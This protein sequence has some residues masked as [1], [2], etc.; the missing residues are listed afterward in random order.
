M[1]EEIRTSA[2]GIP[3]AIKDKDARKAE[4][5]TQFIGEGAAGTSTADY[6]QWAGDKANTGKYEASDTVFVSVNGKRAGRTPL[7]V[8]GKLNGAFQ[9]LAKAVAAKAT[10]LAD[11]AEH[12]GR[13]FNVGEQELATWLTTNGY[14]ETP[15][16][17]IEPSVWTPAKAESPTV[18]AEAPAAKVGP[19]PAKMAQYEAARNK[20]KGAAVAAAPMV[21]AE[22]PAKA[23]TVKA[24]APAKAPMAKAEAP[25]K[26]QALINQ[27]RTLEEVATGH[28]DG[29][30]PNTDDWLTSKAVEEFYTLH[31]ATLAP[32]LGA[33]QE[34]L[35]TA[36]DATRV[37]LMEDAPVA[38]F[39]HYGLNGEL[40][41][42]QAVNKDQGELF[43]KRH[44]PTPGQTPDQ[45][46][47][48]IKH[49]LLDRANIHVLH[50]T[51]D[52]PFPVAPDTAGLYL[53]DGSA[54][55]FTEN[56]APGEEWAK[57]FHEVG[58]HYGL[59]RMVGRDAY[60]AILK[61]LKRM[62]AGDGFA[63]VKEAHR[64]AV[65]AGATGAGVYHETLGY[66]A[67]LSPRH[68]LVRRLITAVRQFLRSIGLVKA[69][70]DADLVGLIQA[71]ALKEGLEGRV[72]LSK[73]QLRSTKEG[74]VIR[75][76]KNALDDL[77]I[78]LEESNQGVGEIDL[79]DRI[80]RIAAG[81]EGER[82][83]PRIAARFFTILG[84][85]LPAIKNG[86]WKTV[87]LLPGYKALE[88]PIS[89]DKLD[90]ISQALEDAFNGVTHPDSVFQEQITA[91]AADI[92]KRGTDVLVPESAYEGRELVDLE[93]LLVRFPQHAELVK[94]FSA[95]GFTLTGS[96]SL[97]AQGS[98]L[99]PDENPF[100]DLDFT[101]PLWLTGEPEHVYRQAVQDV[102]GYTQ[103]QIARFHTIEAKKQV[104]DKAGVDPNTPGFTTFS[105]WVPL[106]PA[107]V[108]TVAGVGKKTQPVVI[109]K[110]TGK[111]Q[112]SAATISIDIFP[113]KNTAELQ[114]AGVRISRWDE[115]IAAKFSF[116]RDGE[117]LRDKDV[118]D[119]ALFKGLVP[120]D[121]LGQKL[122]RRFETHDEYQKVPIFKKYGLEGF[123]NH[124]KLRGK[125]NEAVKLLDRKGFPKTLMEGLSRI[126]VATKSSEPGM[127][128]EN[129]LVMALSQTTL[130]TGSIPDIAA[131][132]AHELTHDLDFQLQR[133]QAET[134]SSP[135]FAIE[136]D[137]KGKVTLGPIIKELYSLY[138]TNKEGLLKTFRY[139]FIDLQNA[140][141]K[142]NQ[143][144]LAGIKSE[145]FAQAGM[146]YWMNP[147]ALQK[148][149]PKTYALLETVYAKESEP[150]RRNHVR[151]ERT[152]LYQRVRGALWPPSS[153]DQGPETGG[154]ANG[155]PR[156]RRPGPGMGRVAPQ[157]A[158]GLLRGRGLVSEPQ[159]S[160]GS[161]TIEPTLDDRGGKRLVV[162]YGIFGNGQLLESFDSA[163]EAAAA[164]KKNRAE[165][166][167]YLGE[168]G[169]KPVRA[170]F[171]N[172]R[173][174]GVL[175]NLDKYLDT[176]KKERE[177]P[178]FAPIGHPSVNP[179]P[180]EPDAHVVDYHAA[181]MR[182]VG[183]LHA[184]SPEGDPAKPKLASHLAPTPLARLESPALAAMA[185]SLR[186][187]KDPVDAAEHALSLMAAPE[188]EGIAQL[189]N[190][191]RR[192][193]AQ[194]LSPERTLGAIEYLYATTLQQSDQLRALTAFVSQDDLPLHEHLLR[195]LDAFDALRRADSSVVADIERNMLPTAE[196]DTAFGQKERDYLAT[197]KAQQ[198]VGNSA[199]EIQV[200]S[201]YERDM[202]VHDTLYPTAA[203][204]KVISPLVTRTDSADSQASKDEKS[205]RA[206]KRL[207]ALEQQLL[208]LQD[209]AAANPSQTAEVA[210][211]DME[212]WLNDGALTEAGEQLRTAMKKGKPDGQESKLLADLQLQ[213][214]WHDATAAP[215]GVLV[216]KYDAQRLGGDK[217]SK[218]SGRYLL[219]ERI[220]T[221]DPDL[222]Q[223]VEDP[224]T[225]DLVT[226]K[227]WVR[228]LISEVTAYW[229]GRPEA[230]NE[231]FWKDNVLEFHAVDK[232]FAPYPGEL[233]GGPVDMAGVLEGKKTRKITLTAK[234]VVKIGKM[235]YKAI[236][237]PLGQTPLMNYEMGLQT[238]LYDSG[239][240]YVMT[241][242]SEQV[243]DRKLLTGPYIAPGVV[244][245]DDKKGLWLGDARQAQARGQADLGVAADDEL[246]A[247]KEWVERKGENSTAFKNWMKEKGLGNLRFQESPKAQKV[248]A[249]LLKKW[250]SQQTNESPAFEEWLDNK[251][252]VAF[253]DRP[254]LQGKEGET[255]DGRGLNTEEEQAGYSARMG[256]IGETSTKVTGEKA[257]PHKAGVSRHEGTEA[258]G[259]VSKIVKAL[260]LNSIHVSLYNR[261]DVSD[262]LDAVEPYTQTYNRLRQGLLGATP[263]KAAVAFIDGRILLYYDKN[264]TGKEL[265][266]ALGHEMGHV[267]LRTVLENERR[268]ST[269][270]WRRLLSQYQASES[271]E[272]FMEWFADQAAQWSLEDRSPKNLIEAFYRRVVDYFNK[273]LGAIGAKATPNAVHAYLDG[274]ALKERAME[275]QALAEAL[276]GTTRYDLLTLQQT[277]HGADTMQ[278]LVLDSPELDFLSP[279][280][281]VKKTAA[282]VKE[283]VKAHQTVNGVV[284]SVTKGR[285][286]VVEWGH[287]V[288]DTTGGW[289]RGLNNPA[290]TMLA[291]M[292]DNGA[293]IGV[294]GLLNTPGDVR[295]TLEAINQDIRKRN[296]ARDPGALPEPFV[297]VN[298]LT[299]RAAQIFKNRKADGLLGVKVFTSLSRNGRR[300][301]EVV[302]QLRESFAAA[303]NRED[304]GH[305]GASEGGY[306]K[307]WHKGTTEAEYQAIG[308][309][310]LRNDPKSQRAKEIAAWLKGFFDE[311]VAPGFTGA[312]SPTREVH[313]GF[314]EDWGMARFYSPEKIAANRQAFLDLLMT[315][316]DSVGWV[317][318]QE[319][320]ARNLTARIETGV[321]LLPQEQPTTLLSPGAASRKRRNI[322]LAIDKLLPFLETDISKT[323]PKYVHSMV[324]RVE[325]D[326]RFS[327]EK[328][329]GK[330][331]VWHRN[332]FFDAL[333]GAAEFNNDL[334]PQRQA[335]IREQINGI[336]EAA[337]GRYGALGA[338][339]RVRTGMSF[340]QTATN[341]LVLPLAAL[342]QGTDFASPFIRTGGDLKNSL[343]GMREAFTAMRNTG[344]DVYKMA[345]M[346]GVIFRDTRNAFAASYLDAPYMTEGA[347]KWNDSLF[348]WNGMQWLTT[349]NRIAAWQTSG[350][351]LKDMAVNGHPDATRLLAQL[352]L[353]TKDLEEWR[354]QEFPDY[355]NGGA[356]DSVAYKVATARTR[357]VQE[358][359]FAPNATQR[360]LLANHP[361]AMLFWSL[362]SFTY[363]YFTQMIKPILREVKNNPRWA[364]KAAAALPL[365]VLLPLAMAGMAFRDELKYGLGRDARSPSDKDD[366]LETTGKV[367]SRTGIM[368]PLQLL[369]DADTASSYGRSFFFALAS[370]TLSKAEE[371]FRAGSLTPLMPGLSMLPA[372][373]QALMRWMAED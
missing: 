76:L 271:P 8:D 315:D 207:P 294:D 278:R 241:Q 113:Y 231:D 236:G 224:K 347:Q 67:E 78:T 11:N 121:T 118:I 2:R 209:Q 239:T 371:A 83:I 357:F 373:R 242:A 43:S 340:I 53:P 143:E 197:V 122:E 258:H 235:M 238:L 47:A 66:L 360:P 285:R 163:E 232:L 162:G 325:W 274:L 106:D 369:M 277:Y 32:L 233:S 350:H 91:F 266:W 358:S 120:R 283:W 329:N 193:F 115:I 227:E 55:F 30:L 151:Y 46:R 169:A 70:T 310:L 130:E 131:V 86:L 302:P 208:A 270:L 336:G 135:L 216:L 359:N 109:D 211:G 89:T 15:G 341:F 167:G 330:K 61:D 206:R 44:A 100:H 286:T 45:F 141:A 333:R 153:P 187:I 332:V 348:K 186:A 180:R 108:L 365:L 356:K 297:D 124:P 311:Y 372:E 158:G 217:G 82:L 191:Y 243:A 361:Y 237:S 289:L 262:L 192:I 366:W 90:I 218:H 102:L 171:A 148:A 323:L 79:L 189:L 305:W 146:L 132:I 228:R 261:D 368:G 13:G 155:R 165:Y 149:A 309:E 99:R 3:Q 157:N 264:L 136:K 19:S 9:N 176:D 175:E 69:Y 68:G 229:D 279:T 343:K 301:T 174:K 159:F 133:G 317:G 308:E 50:R 63:S 42:K 319:A 246:R 18:Q 210:L 98:V 142:G 34:Q 72:G 10:I 288:L 345:E 273:L 170:E 116:I 212:A 71:A 327:D 26:V 201:L 349:F 199:G 250:Q 96:A 354:D 304:K 21:K 181:L 73:G 195:A 303:V 370:P 94:K 182:H 161:L 226:P 214:A 205:W 251:E 362:K 213:R 29:V 93:K 17:G 346:M 22:A 316:D 16:K 81:A 364:S 253:L 168:A 254:D 4:L 183:Q 272:S 64:R 240:H 260:N 247:F 291:D 265:A 234:Q 137:A 125:V 259:V 293:R 196:A 363:S 101:S 263:K 202:L 334:P 257:L 150:A 112:P 87:E 40:Y 245:T 339:P 184:A 321:E 129:K 267:V 312:Y 222:L 60:A 140:I 127:L 41:K 219:V 282:A 220:T 172:P 49:K 177:K 290:S 244:V 281:V 5:M 144:K 215:Y 185:E 296:L 200:Q 204:G 134:H 326:R 104:W 20:A 344:G 1:A 48:A 249:T 203:L 179:I 284:T 173:Y 287:D 126:A 280:G 88:S 7:F 314:R 54:W 225:K 353:T 14:V 123:E 103:H 128:W 328:W 28:D 252:N 117:G 74:G 111:S 31:Q 152:R 33:A 24:E 114:K 338:D 337:M 37:A 147:A 56:I 95:A 52:A 313:I 139:P 6:A 248:Y 255:T 156:N 230:R 178:R 292:L 194:N 295:A 166:E 355:T 80:G 84:H 119:Y 77:S 269:V 223:L 59:A 105:Y 62:V 335:Q 342:S 36:D 138:T 12:R 85:P 299:G 164:L 75:T 322:P 25:A 154:K 35:K 198:E 307:F 318:M 367:I 110:A 160:R 276:R 221:F 188:A 190:Q 324:R 351:W 298:A 39:L 27:L 306:Y 300:T 23:P 107:H 97:G 65:A 38:D 145:A 352:D 51:T 275:Y 331:W 58:A 92:L 268:R 57:V 256:R 320:Q